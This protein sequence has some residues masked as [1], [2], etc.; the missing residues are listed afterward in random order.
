MK[1]ENNRYEE[2]MIDL[3]LLKKQGQRQQHDLNTATLEGVSD[4]GAYIV[5]IQVP[6]FQYFIQ[7]FP[8][9]AYLILCTDVWNNNDIDK[10]AGMETS[11]SE[12]PRP[13]PPPPA[14]G[15]S[16]PPTG[17]SL[18]DSDALL[19]FCSDDLTPPVTST[20]SASVS[21]TMAQSLPTAKAMPSQLVI[22]EGTSGHLTSLS[23][24]DLGGVEPS[25]KGV[26]SVTTTTAT[27]PTTGGVAGGT[28]ILDSLGLTTG[29][30]Q[31]SGGGGA[32][33]RD[34]KLWSSFDDTIETRASIAHI[35]SSKQGFNPKR[36]TSAASQFIYQ[37]FYYR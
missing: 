34:L 30:R 19:N 4:K 8:D 26:T 28:T 1:L 12:F 3:A 17:A 13:P 25:G 10:L 29:Q 35:D 21:A 31:S 7:P 36:R 37:M 22:N 20:V 33:G 24:L 6:K 32:H 18:I 2:L 9:I 16:T 15:L 27:V 11:A 14:P 23:G 5:K